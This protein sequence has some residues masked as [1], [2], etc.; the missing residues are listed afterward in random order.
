MIMRLDD[1]DRRDHDDS[2]MIAATLG[3]IPRCATG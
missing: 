1:Q 3:T 2:I